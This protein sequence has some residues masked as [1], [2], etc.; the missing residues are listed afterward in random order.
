MDQMEELEA[1]IN[2]TKQDIANLR[3]RISAM[4]EESTEYASPQEKIRETVR[5]KFYGYR[6]GSEGEILEEKPSEIETL[7]RERL[8]GPLER[9]AT[10]PETGQTFEQTIQKRLEQGFSEEEVDELSTA[11]RTRFY[12]PSQKER[13]RE[14]VSS[15]IAAATCPKR[16]VVL[17][18]AF[19][20]PVDAEKLTGSCDWC[21]Y[22]NGECDFQ[23]LKEIGRSHQT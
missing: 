16:R 3:R 7:I 19:R 13:D 5:Q 21:L 17:E 14:E 6:R 9:Q 1:E 18:A 8:Y 15:E 20:G 12:G 22:R 10:N 11:I 2:K 4:E 23:T